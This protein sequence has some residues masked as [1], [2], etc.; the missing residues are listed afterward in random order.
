MFISLLIN[1]DDVLNVISVSGYSNR[2]VDF[3]SPFLEAEPLYFKQHAVS[4]GAKVEVVKGRS[5]R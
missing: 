2:S 1:F 3:P 4:S 5:I